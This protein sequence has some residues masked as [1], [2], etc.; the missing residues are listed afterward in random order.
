MRGI[1]KQ[2]T[3]NTAGAGITNVRLK[4]SL[5]YRHRTMGNRRSH[6]Q[7]NKEKTHD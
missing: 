3:V 1:G 6:P 5:T 2:R 4:N 7:S